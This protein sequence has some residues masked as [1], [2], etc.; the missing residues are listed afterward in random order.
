MC[1]NTSIIMNL[2]INISIS[3][4][5][6]MIIL[7]SKVIIQIVICV[8]RWRFTPFWLVRIMKEINLHSICMVRMK[9]WVLF[10]ILEIFIFLVVFRLTVSIS[11]MLD[12]NH[13]IGIVFSV[14]NGNFFITLVFHFTFDNFIFTFDFTLVLMFLRLFSVRR[15][16][17]THVLSIV[18]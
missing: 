12:F 6:S 3:F 7:R 13:F 10:F 14:R 5:F 1:V 18:H 15:E 17:P 9:R 2:S 4:N 8:C 16:R 11:R